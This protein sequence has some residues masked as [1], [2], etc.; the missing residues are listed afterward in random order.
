MSRRVDLDRPHWQPFRHLA[1][2]DVPPK[3]LA[4]L[5]GF[6]AWLADRRTAEVDRRVLLDFAAES[7]TRSC[8]RRLAEAFDQV[9]PPDHALRR[10]LRE[11]VLEHERRWTGQPMRLEILQAPWWRPFLRQ[12]DT[13]AV[14]YERLKT[15]DRWLAH[16]HAARIAQPAAEDYLDYFAEARSATP[17]MHLQEAYE[18]LGLPAI[19]AVALELPKA[20]R[21]KRAACAT[22]PAGPGRRPQARVMSV[23]PDELPPDWQAALAGMRAGRRR[24]GTKAPAPS[25]IRNIET[26]LCQYAFHCRRKGRAVELSL[27][28]AGSYLTW[29][30][31]TDTPQGDPRRPAT[32]EMRASALLRF[33]RYSGVPQAICDG[34]ALAEACRKSESEGVIAQKH[35]KL[36]KIGPVRRILEK[37]V[38]LRL[39]A[40]AQRT[41]TWRMAR[42]N[43]ATSLALF[44]LLPV[45]LADTQLIWGRH[46][47]W[48]ETRY[49]IDVATSKTGAP[50]RGRLPEFLTPFLDAL[51]LR[52]LDERFLPQ[53]REQAM[54]EEHPLLLKGNETATF[55]GY[56]SHVWKQ[57]FGTGQHI[58]RTMVHTELGQLGPEGVA[59]ALALCAQRDPRTADYYQN[60]A[61][62][63]ALLV[64]SL[65]S[66]VE[67]ITPEEFA[68][69]FP[70]LDPPEGQSEIAMV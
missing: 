57:Y 20:I 16:L 8:L 10:D 48:A 54:A 36:S 33:A 4:R 34:L 45:R 31:D 24:N 44:V 19:P 63:D 49:R 70:D 50:V 23:P 11:A 40:T 13:D 66:L 38:D 17:L 64:Q 29:L 51:L 56:V 21:R 37:A 47:T 1:L 22:T 6:L 65:E 35:D 26:T 60:E 43:H 18:A 7:A 53:R 5:D 25:I 58:A 28:S 39:E 3:H 14:A 41:L 68:K 59:S 30:D 62:H 42:L 12:A 61:M 2:A 67:D 15:V 27:A 46:V 52:G 69:Y 55:G 32:L 9:L